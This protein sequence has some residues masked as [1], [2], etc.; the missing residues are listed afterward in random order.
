MHGWWA[1]Q[2]RRQMPFGRCEAP[3]SRHVIVSALVLE[4]APR[5]IV[6]R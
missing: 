2:H 6:T 5:A 1:W 3:F 4:S